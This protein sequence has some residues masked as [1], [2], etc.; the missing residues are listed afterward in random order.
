V[1][2]QH[3]LERAI[4]MAEVMKGSYM[5]FSTDSED[6]KAKQVFK[7]MAEDMERHVMIL[8]SRLQYLAQ[9]NLL[10]RQQGGPNGQGEGSQG[11]GN[12]QGQG[13]GQGNGQANGQGSGQGQNGQQRGGRDQRQNQTG[14]SGGGG[15]GCGQ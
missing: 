9:Y 13:N 4:A 3:D 10:N 2:V 6:E 15:Q 14:Q 5:L 12:G 1:T 8:K 11:R 7:Q